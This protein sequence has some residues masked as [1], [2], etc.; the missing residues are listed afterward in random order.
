MSHEIETF[1]KQGPIDK[2]LIKL[3]II[4]RLNTFRKAANNIA[5]V[6]NTTRAPIM[7]K[8]AI[9][10]NALRTLNILIVSKKNKI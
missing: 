3:S 1:N 10:I 6:A 4:L 7:E 5:L 9:T 8:R 2:C